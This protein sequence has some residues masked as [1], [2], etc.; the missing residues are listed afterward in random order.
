MYR[1]VMKIIIKGRYT[2]MKIKKYSSAEPLGQFQPDLAQSIL[3]WGGI[4]FVQMKGHT[5]F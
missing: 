4:K 1:W 2:L 5:L 3:W